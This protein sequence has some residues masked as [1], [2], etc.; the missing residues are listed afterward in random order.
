M[1]SRKP[2]QV[3]GFLIGAVVLALFAVLRS[4]FTSLALL[5]F[6]VFG[7][8][9]ISPDGAG[10][11]L[12]RWHFRGRAGADKRSAAWRRRSP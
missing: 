9:N 2:L 11:R 7:L 6:L 1:G 10:P 3:W 12:R 4:Q 8:F 5:A